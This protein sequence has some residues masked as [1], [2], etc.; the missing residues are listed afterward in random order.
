MEK[1]PRSIRRKFINNVSVIIR[2][3]FAGRS[4][5][6]ELV[7][8]NLKVRYSRPFLGFFWTFLSP[9]LV[10]V[11]YYI[12]F[13]RILKSRVDE[14]PFFVYLMSAVFPWRFFSDSVFCSSTSLLDN[15]NLI[16]ESSFAQYLIPISVAIE[17]MIIFLP[18]LCILIVTS[19]FIFKGFNDLILLL[20]LILV[21]HMIMT[22][23]ISIIFSLLYIK[24]RD[25]K[26]ILEVILLLL[27]NFSPAFYSIYLVK[28]SFNPLMYRLYILNPFVCMLNMYRVSIF[29]DFYSKTAGD[30]GGAYIF[31]VPVVFAVL[32]ILLGFYMYNKNK[33]IINDYLSY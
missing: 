17:N 20:P 12:V 3:I 5:I 26:Y 28:N 33:S 11:I 31:I 7:V 27:F 23:G 18:T 2:E 24:W 32:T 19:F 22:I 25:I 29:K 6:R 30:I 4:L 9:F 13:S 21:I 1:M 14:A 16:R 10:T 15:K 8:K